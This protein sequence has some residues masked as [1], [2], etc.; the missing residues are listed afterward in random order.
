MKKDVNIKLISKQTDGDSTD[1]IELLTEG[2]F[3]YGKDSYEIS[4]NET[5][6]TG[7]EG[8]VTKLTVMGSEKVEM[9]RSGAASSNIVIEMGRK[10]HCH[11]G[12]PFGEFMVGVTAK[13]ISSNISENGGDLDFSY[14]IDVNSSYVGDF[15]IKI[16]VRTIN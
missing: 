11:Y 5:E 13:Q 4:Y 2:L 8:A 9:V 15:E 3:R 6:A 14:V 1:E 7:F 12:T 10:H 16:Q